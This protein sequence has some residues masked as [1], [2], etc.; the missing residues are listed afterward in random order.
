MAVRF[1]RDLGGFL[2]RPL[3][4][5]EC[6]QQLIRQLHAREASFLDV[7]ERGIFGNARSPY[8]ALMSHAQ[9]EQE[10]VVA[11]VQAV[12]V[13]GTLARLYDAGVSVTLDEFKGR[14]PIRRRGL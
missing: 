10:D 2:R 9:I 1:G 5:D 13:E 4:P 11:W 12:G 6:R 3:T 8:R 7:V 14:R